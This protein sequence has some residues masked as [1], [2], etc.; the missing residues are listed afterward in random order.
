MKEQKVTLK[1]AS[2]RDFIK[3]AALGTAAFYIVP[4]HVLGRGYTAPSDKLNIAGIG[5]GGKGSSDIANSYQKGKENIVALCD[6]D[7][8]QGIPTRKIHEKATFYKDYRVLLEKEAKN[9]DAVI[10]STPDHTHAVIAMAAMS[11]GKHVYVQKP[12]AHS[13]WEVRQMTEAAHRYKVV[14]QMGNQG[15]SG[16]GVRQMQE[17]YESGVIG[18]VD[19]VHCWT[20]RPVWPQGNAMPKTP[21]EIPKELD[22]ELWLG[23]A[24]KNEFFPQLLPFNWRGYWD[25]GTGSLGDMGCHIMQTAHRILSLGYPSEV[26]CSVG[27]TWSGF[28]KE[29]VAPES[30]PASSVI[31]LKFPRAKGKDLKMTWYDGGILPQ[32]P[33]LLPADVSYAGWFGGGGGTMLIGKKGIMMSGVYGREPKLYPEAIATKGAK[34]KQKIPRITDGWGI[35][36]HIEWVEACKLGYKKKE[37]SS[38]FDIAG[39]VTEAVLMGNIAIRSYWLAE[40][41]DTSKRDNYTGRKRLLW[42]GKNMRI[43][44]YDLANQFVKRDYRQGW[45]I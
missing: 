45:S 3:K 2:R 12:M 13:I 24:P 26:E 38:D 23:P 36:H 35:G 8:R 1:S 5:V 32:R 29:T 16:E 14:T 44:N 18:D 9:I 10:V 21:N 11:L 30:C 4:R 22:Y 41:K 42:D 37:L 39:P 33:E 19:E 20:N 28:F 6:V 40:G 43:T 7:D 31:H 25:Y 34:V 17:W 15:A 27:A